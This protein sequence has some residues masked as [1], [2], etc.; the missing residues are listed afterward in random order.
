MSV[1]LSVPPAFQE[2]PNKK[3]SRTSKYFRKCYP[4]SVTPA[5]ESRYELKASP[6]IAASNNKQTVQN[7]LR[8]C[9]PYTLQTGSH[10]STGT[11]HQGISITA[12]TCNLTISGTELLKDCYMSIAEA[13]SNREGADMMYQSINAF[14]LRFYRFN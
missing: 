11:E 14:F 2:L 5:L 10:C 9:Q 12:V 1:N 8:F 13:N 7:F 3:I 6:G 4:L